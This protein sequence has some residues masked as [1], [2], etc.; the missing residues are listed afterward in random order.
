[1]KKFAILFVISLVL[2]GCFV[3]ASAASTSD[4]PTHTDVT[5]LSKCNEMIIITAVGNPTTGYTW[6]EP[7]VSNGL[8]IVYSDYTQ[9][10][11]G[12]LG[13]GGLF[14]W[15]VSADTPGFYLFKT[16]YNRGWENEPKMTLNA[17]FVYLPEFVDIISGVTNIRQY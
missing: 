1:M 16:E 9:S 17:V 15:G 8:E 3:S 2:L 14:E 4:E 12:M 5:I 11:P 13:T 6:S 7:A 10:K